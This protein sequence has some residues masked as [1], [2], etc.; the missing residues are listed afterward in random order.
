TITEHSKELSSQKASLTALDNA[1]KFKV[2]SQTFNQSTTTINNNINRAKEEAINSSNSHAD[3]KVNEALNNAKAFVNSEITNVNT[4]LN[5]NTSEINIL[6]GQIESKVSQSDIDKSI[7]NIEFGGRNLFLKSKGPFKSSNEYVGISITSVV[8]KYLNKKITISADVK[9]NK[10]GKIRFYSLGGYSVGFWVERDVTTEWT[11]IKATGKF[12]LNDEKQKWCD[13]S[14]YGTYG[15]GL[16]TEVRNVKIELGELASDY[17]EA[18]EDT[19]KLIIDNIKTV[20]D[21]ISTVESK[22][23]QENNSIKA[24]VQDLNSTTQSITTNVSNINRDLTSKINSNLDAAK[25]FATDIATN[26]ANT[27]KQEAISSANSHADNIAA[28]KATEAINNAKAYTNAEITTVNSKVH[29]VESNLNILSD[30]INTKVSQSDI[31]KAVTTIRTERIIYARGTGNDYPANSIVKVNGKTI[32]DGQGR[33]LR[34][35]ALNKSTLERV[36]LQDYDTF[37]SED[38]KVS[39]V[40]K[41]NELNNGDFIIIITS[42]DASYPL[43]QPIKEA[44]EKIGATLFDNKQG[45]YREAYAL[46]GK[47]KLG[48]GNGVEMFIPRTAN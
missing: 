34:I 17:T 19:D 9:A 14:F 3:S 35:N 7:Q 5:K 29:N 1:L 12:T 42:Q 38:A 36:F 22:L 28:S 30:R 25:N 13:L 15:S 2:D 27:A 32:T 18:P 16:F 11:R 6:K 40:N 21:K 43:H 39:F 48:R 37:G 20:T 23:T 46:I 24:S 44:L 4:H 47:S 31:D 26:K 41:I 8:E 33:G 10:V 45:T